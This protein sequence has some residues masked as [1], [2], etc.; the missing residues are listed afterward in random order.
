MTDRIVLRRMVFQGRHGYTDEER[1]EPQPFEVDVELV[2]NLQPAGVEDDLERSV[3]YGRAFEIAREL[4]ESTNFKLVE[5]I[6]E[7]IAHELLRLL[8]VNEVGVR[9]RKMRV[10]VSGRI[11]HAEVEIWRTRSDGDRRR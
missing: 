8:P 10:P 9:V 1:A 3:D 11:D 4:V 5:A 6:A 7:G 2:L